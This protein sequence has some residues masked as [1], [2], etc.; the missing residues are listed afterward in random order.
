MPSP[1]AA[2]PSIAALEDL[3]PARFHVPKLPVVARSGP[4]RK[5]CVGSLSRHGHGSDHDARPLPHS[6]PEHLVVWGIVLSTYLFLFFSSSGR[7]YF[8]NEAI[9]RRARLPLVL[10]FP[11]CP[12]SW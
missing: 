2:C 5:L 3:R 7:G 4:I 10:P 12:R 8:P 6:R 1:L 11:F 9:I